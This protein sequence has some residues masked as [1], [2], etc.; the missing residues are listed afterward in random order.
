M[1]LAPNVMTVVVTLV[2]R[3]SIA[4]NIPYAPLDASRFTS[5][6]SSYPAPIR[7]CVVHA[8]VTRFYATGAVMS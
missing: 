8:S 3:S 1:V 5:Y 2:R 7:T 6:P 4:S